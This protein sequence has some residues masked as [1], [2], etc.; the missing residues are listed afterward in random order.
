MLLDKPT[1]YFEYKEMIFSLDLSSHSESL[2]RANVLHFTVCL[3]V[4]ES[5]VSKYPTGITYIY[6]RIIVIV[7]NQNK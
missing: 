4:F 3:H 1:F 2:G 5:T 7:I 6:L